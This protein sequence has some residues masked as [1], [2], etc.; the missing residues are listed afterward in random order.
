MNDQELKIR[1]FYINIEISSLTFKYYQ[2]LTDNKILAIK[3]F[4]YRAMYPDKFQDD[5]VKRMEKYV[6]A[7]DWIIYII[8]KKFE[9]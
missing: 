7:R 9:D 1:L 4:G 3:L 2:I 8:I 5:L 6:N